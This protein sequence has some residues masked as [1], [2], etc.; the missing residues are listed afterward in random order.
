MVVL[1]L[2]FSL[3]IILA[4]FDVFWECLLTVLHIV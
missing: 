1:I 4:A 2:I 3:A